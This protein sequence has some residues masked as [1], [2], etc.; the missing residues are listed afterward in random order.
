MGKHVHR[1]TIDHHRSDTAYQR[2][3]KRVAIMLTSSVGTMTCFWIF[4]ALSLISLP[5]VIASGSVIALVAWVTQT[6]IQLVLL[7]ALMVGQN[8]QTAAADA[9]SAKEFEDIEI[10]VDRLDVH[11]QGGI[12]DVLDAIHEMDKHGN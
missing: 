10:I 9:R 8:L 7:P 1:R 12:K 5:A 6:C 4:L 11:T 3:N 2:F